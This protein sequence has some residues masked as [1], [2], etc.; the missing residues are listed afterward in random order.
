MKSA[1]VLLI[2]PQYTIYKKDFKRCMPPLGLAYIAALL[3]QNNFEVK[4][5]DAYAEGFE[6]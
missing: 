3:E 1:K 2:Q 4:I 6:N 5:L